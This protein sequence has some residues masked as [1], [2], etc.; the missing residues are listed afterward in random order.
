MIRIGTKYTYVNISIYIYC[1]YKKA[2]LF[3]YR[4]QYLSILFY[5]VLWLI[6][7][8]S[9]ALIYKLSSKVGNSFC[10][11]NFVQAFNSFVIH[12][13]VYYWLV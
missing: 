1:K 3:I 5:F 4:Y 12:S 7:F 13:L 8:N 10:G 9:T 6:E 11:V 2:I